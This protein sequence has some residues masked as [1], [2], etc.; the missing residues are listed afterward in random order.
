M[1]ERR[2]MV[3]LDGTIHYGLREDQKR[4]IELH[5]LNPDK[6]VVMRNDRENLFVR[7]DKT[8]YLLP[9]ESDT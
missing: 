5:G 1:A 4:L 8:Y 6:A 2:P 3:S 7:I 9:K